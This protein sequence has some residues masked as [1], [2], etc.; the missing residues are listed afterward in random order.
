MR[1]LELGCAGGGNLA[2]MAA[3]YPDSAFVGIDL[4][5][6]HTAAANK[7]VADLNDV[8]EAIVGEDVL[9]AVGHREGAG[10]I[11]VGTRLPC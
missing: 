4:S 1:V 6:G 7:M 3:A 11:A 8:L 2:P 9:E 5:K 10:Q